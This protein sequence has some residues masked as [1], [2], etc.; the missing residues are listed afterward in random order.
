M[1]AGNE[2]A[3]LDFGSSVNRVAFSNNDQY[4]LA[5]GHGNPKIYK[6]SDWSLV[7]SLK[8]DQFVNFASGVFS[9]DGQYVVGVG[10]TKEARVNVFLWDFKSGK[11]L[12]QFNHKG[13]KIESVAWHPNGIY[14]V[15]VGHDPHVYVYRLAD[16]LQYANDAIPVAHK[17]WAGDYAE[18]IDFNA[19]GS[20]VVSAHQNGLINSGHG[21]AKS[22]M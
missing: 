18:F 16:I 17:V 20:F 13:K 21:W 15:Q 22:L 8:T 2:I 12:K 3:K 4:L 6:V 19:D 5:I 11:L 1:P 14:I 10:S 7:Q 9:P